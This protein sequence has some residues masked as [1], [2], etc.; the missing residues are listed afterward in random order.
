MKWPYDDSNKLLMMM[1]MFCF[2]NLK[3]N[4]YN[5]IILYYNNNN[6]NITLIYLYGSIH[7]FFIN[8]KCHKINNEK[9]KDRRWEFFG[10]KRSILY[11]FLD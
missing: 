4:Y 8:I 10:K 2:I 1:K 3:T 7:Y 11:W 9:Q 6:N 5:I